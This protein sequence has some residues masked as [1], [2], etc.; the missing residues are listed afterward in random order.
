MIPSQHTE[1]VA[2]CESREFGRAVLNGVAERAG[3]VGELLA[4]L[5]A[6]KDV[7]GDLFGRV[8]HQGTLYEATPPVLSWILHAIE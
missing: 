1:I 3:D 4:Q 8:L 6:G 2:A 5:G 7:W